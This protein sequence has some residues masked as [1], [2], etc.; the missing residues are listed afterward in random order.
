MSQPWLR[1]YRGTVNNPKLQRLGLEVVGFW[2]NCLCLSDDDGCLPPV[3]DIAWSMRLNETQVE[4]FLE[5][6]Q[7]NN[8]VDAEGDGT[9]RLHD[10][11]EHQKVSDLS[12]D[13]VRK[14]REKQRKTDDYPALK[15]DETQRNVSETVQIRTDTD[16]KEEKNMSVPAAPDGFEKFWKAYPRTPNMS[17]AAALKAWQ[18]QKSKLPPQEILLQAVDRYRAFLAHE[19]KKNGREYPAKHAQG[20]LNEQR[21]LGF[22][23]DVPGLDAPKHSADWADSLPEWSQ[24]KASVPPAAWSAFFAGCRPNGSVSNLIAPSTFVMEQIEARY[25]QALDAIFNGQFNVKFEARN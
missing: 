12:T 9:L 22:M 6:L 17:K 13:R 19:T 4:T 21:W 20:W 14:Y 10:W 18:K 15:Q 25:G 24:F 16:K 1:L 5:T 23:A 3:A 2:T 7:R 11:S 8:L